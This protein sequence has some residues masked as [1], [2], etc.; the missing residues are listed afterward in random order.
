[1]TSARTTATTAT[2]MNCQTLTRRFKS[3]T[4]RGRHTQA[5]SIV[6]VPLDGPGSREALVAKPARRGEYDPLVRGDG[7]R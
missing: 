1:M 2:T 3:L 4:P 5:V 7:Q 6:T